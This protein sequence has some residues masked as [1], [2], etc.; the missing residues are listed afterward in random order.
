MMQLLDVKD[1]NEA[2]NISA[3]FY[4]QRYLKNIS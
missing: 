1:F 4:A 2:R 3:L